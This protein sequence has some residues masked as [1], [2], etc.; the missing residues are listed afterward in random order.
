MDRRTLLRRVGAAGTVGSLA[1]CLG[2]AVPGDSSGADG[3]AGTT[4]TETGTTPD[5]TETSDGTE[6]PD[7]TET[8]SDGADAVIGD[9][10]A[11][12][13]PETN[14]P[15]AV[16]VKNA[17]ADST[18]LDLSVSA[19]GRGEVWARTVELP[20]G[21][22]FEL[23]LVAPAHYTVTV[24]RAADGGVAAE[25]DVPLSWFDCNDSGTTVELT[26]DGAETTTFTTEMA[27]PAAELA[28]TSFD[29]GEGQ[30]GNAD[31]DAADV[32]YDG[33]TVGVTGTVSMPDPCRDVSLADAT[34]DEETS[35]LSLTVEVAAA[36]PAQTCIACVGVR[37][38]EATADFDVDLPDRVVVRH[39]GP[40]RETEVVTRAVRGGGTD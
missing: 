26:A 23:R 31:A 27:C 36:D 17:A 2:A 16:T 34:Y 33:E 28:G 12:A 5:E 40:D 10:S 8:A 6:T 20:S 30:C 22:A 24:C 14:K 7:E 35:T 21:G 38:Y 13:F 9:R 29:A 18:R 39:T 4:E 11:V 25:V 32:R 37:D 15:H 19:E 3:D 1:G